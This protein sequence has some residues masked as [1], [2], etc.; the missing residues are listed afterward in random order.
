MHL[1]EED[2]YFD[3][4]FH[5]WTSGEEE[6]GGGFSYTRELANPSWI[7][8]GVPV[9][10][11]VGASG[12][13]PGSESFD[14]DILFDATD[15]IRGD[16]FANVKVSSNDIDNPVINVPVQLI[17]EGPLPVIVVDPK[18]IFAVWSVSTGQLDSVVTV[19]INNAG[20]DRPE[21]FPVCYSGRPL[22]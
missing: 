10:G 22:F 17:V 13:I 1:I 16:Y 4:V 15:L 12:T 3:V 6:G 2:F 19:E 9:K 20:D 5:S 11:L 18:P 8:A 21:Y 7:S 14:V